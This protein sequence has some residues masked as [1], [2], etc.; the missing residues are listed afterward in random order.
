MS[1]TS[2]Q[3]LTTTKTLSGGVVTFVISQNPSRRY[4][5]L[6]NTGSGGT[7]TFGTT[8]GLVVGAGFISLDPATTTTGQGGSAEYTSCIPQNP[9]YAISTAGTTITV[10]EG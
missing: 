9:I 10:S 8:T 5:F 4:L 1:I 6:Q 2:V 3:L 7:V